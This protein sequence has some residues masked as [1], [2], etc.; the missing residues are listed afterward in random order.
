MGSNSSICSLDTDRCYNPRSLGNVPICNICILGSDESKLL[1]VVPVVP[2]AY[3]SR[4]Y[5]SLVVKASCCPKASAAPNKLEFIESA[6]SASSVFQ[7]E[8]TP[9]LSAVSLDIFP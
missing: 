3:V 5:L 1:E 7:S 8:Q 6:L 2:F 4:I 9:S